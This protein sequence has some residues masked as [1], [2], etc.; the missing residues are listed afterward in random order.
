[1]IS[2]LCQI[3]V[4]ISDAAKRWDLRGLFGVFLKCAFH[5]TQHR[6]SERFQQEM[7]ESRSDVCVVRLLVQLVQAA[8]DAQD[9]AGRCG[10][11]R[12][13]SMDYG[14]A[15]ERNGEGVT[16]TDKPDGEQHADVQR[17]SKRTYLLLKT[18]SIMV[19]IGGL[20]ASAQMI[21]LAYLSG[22][23]QYY[24]GSAIILVLGASGVLMAVFCALAF[25]IASYTDQWLPVK[26]DLPKDKQTDS[27]L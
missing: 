10:W 16:M 23:F 5:D 4:A 25:A 22:Q 26:S 1:M 7:G 13:R 17:A 27:A 19:A 24:W 12:E 3:H 2:T 15:V 8:H 6:G 20:L 21:W 11:T 9:D 18:L 14:A